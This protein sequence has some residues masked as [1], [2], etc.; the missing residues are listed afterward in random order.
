MISGMY[1][2]VAINGTKACEFIAV[3]IIDGIVVAVKSRGL[4]YQYDMIQG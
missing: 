1:A 2:I 3:D 4:N